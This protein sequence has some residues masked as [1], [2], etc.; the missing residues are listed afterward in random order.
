M[1]RR[2]FFSKSLPAS[3]AALG[4]PALLKAKPANPQSPAMNGNFIHVVYFW[5]KDPASSENSDQLLQGIKGYLGEIDVI[6]DSFIG[7]PA[8]TPREVVDNSYSFSIILTFANRADQ[9]VYQAHPSHLKFI[10][11]SGHLWE[12]VQV[13]DSLRV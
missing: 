4:I 7:T 10:E 3:I 6:L 5:L 1:K 13:Y 11:E 2:N 12:R 9:D 8:Q